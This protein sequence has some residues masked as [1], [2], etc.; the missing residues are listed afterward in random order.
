[1]RYLKGTLYAI[2]AQESGHIQLLL[3]A[4]I[5]ALSF[6]SLVVRTASSAVD[7][8]LE[9]KKV[10]EQ[11][12]R[13]LSEVQHEAEDDSTHED[14][15]H[16]AQDLPESPVAALPSSP[17]IAP[18]H[19]P[20]HKKTLLPVEPQQRTRR[21]QKKQ[22]LAAILREEGLAA[23]EAARWIAAART[24]KGFN[25]LRAGQTITLFF[26]T[27]RQRRELTTVSY[28]VD[29]KTRLV[30]EKRADGP[31]VFRR[32]ILP[33]VLV[34]RAI[35]G[36]ITNSLY[37][38]AKRAGVPVRLLDDL[39]DMDWDIDLSSDLRAGDVFK[40]IFEEFQQ[41]GTTVGYGKILAAEIVNR[42]KPYTLYSIPGSIATG[43]TGAKRA[44]Q[45]FLRYPLKFS[46]ISSVFT[47]GRF[48]PILKRSRPHLGVDFAAPAGT[49]VRSVAC[50]K[51][52][53]AGRF[54][55]YGNFVR[56][57]HPGPYASAYAHLQR[58]AK[59][60]TVG[61]WVERGQVIGYVGAT[62]FA[63]GPHLHFELYKDGNYINPLTAKLPTVEDTVEDPQQ[64][65]LQVQARQYLRE[66]LAALQVGN[67]PVSIVRNN[68][69]RE[70]AV[71]LAH[72]SLG[73]AAPQRLA[74]R[75]TKTST[76]RNASA[77][78]SRS[79]RVVTNQRRA[80]VRR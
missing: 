69:L 42:G 48:H 1:M 47:T 40:V 52:V 68:P 59:S 27:A 37:H 13:R 11:L 56:I 25:T 17:S 66:Q 67:R 39:A 18:A 58:I 72:P 46:R 50:G 24:A 74:L 49:P 12:K 71:H 78:R 9:K 53:Y 22:T 51:V 36:P 15:D 14:D 30:L 28:A 57:D 26:S 31:I 55:G 6:L 60:V 63:T 73:E 8:T 32:E 61:S 76:Q 10:T 70:H 5:L 75:A 29:Q 7:P 20:S 38:A 21:V 43:E 19:E 2:L 80:A 16:R 65:R 41:E 35:G 77:S 54:G 79:L 3:I 4:P 23:E 34:W 33:T 45:S 64:K 44:S 62:G